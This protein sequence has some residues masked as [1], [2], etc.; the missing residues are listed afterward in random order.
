MILFYYGTDDGRMS[1]AVHAL[2]KRYRSKHGATNLFVL[3]TDDREQLIRARQALKN[4]SFF[5][6][7][8]FIA[9]RYVFDTPEAAD[10]LCETLADGVIADDTN[11]VLLVWQQGTEKKLTK[12]HKALFHVLESHSKTMS[13]YEPQTGGELLSW[14]QAFCKSRGC[15]LSSAVASE[16]I[17]ITGEESWTLMNEMAKLCAWQ[18]HGEIPRSI[19]HR[20]ATPTAGEANVFALTDAVSA[21]NKRAVLRELDR[22]LGLG[23]EPHYLLAMYAFAIRNLITIKDLAERGMTVHAIARTGGLHPFVVKKGLAASRRFQTDEL[24]RAH[25]WLSQADR[26]TKN[27]SRDTL[28]TLYDFVLS[29]M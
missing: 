1:H 18:R 3:D 10:M 5:S 26:D 27:G 4:R 9:L 7:P 14:M 19:V 2:T 29:V 11:T 22:Q 28:D 16:L 13:A 20:M 23:S 6:E 8:T 15:T 25:T 21:R 12:Q 17:A 24:L